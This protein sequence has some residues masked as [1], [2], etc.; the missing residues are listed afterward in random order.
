M[1]I[2]P[3][4]RRALAAVLVC[5]LSACASSAKRQAIERERDPQYQ[6]EKAV[7]CMQYGMVDEA[8]KYLQTALTLNP[9]HV[10]S[11][12]LQGLAHMRKGNVEEALRSFQG[13]TAIDPNFSEAH[14]N[15]GTTLQEKGRIEE[16]ETA[17]RKAYE[18]DQNYNAAYNLA[19]ISYE[20]KKSDDALT[21]I[22]RSIEKY[23]RSLLAFNLQGLILES[24]ERFDE[25]IS[26]Y[27]QALRL[28]PG[29]LSVQYNLGVAYYKKK[30]F[31]R[32]K[33]TLSR[34]LDELVK[35][36]QIGKEDLRAR[37]ADVLKRIE[38]R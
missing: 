37:V 21:W 25:A 19:R 7:V 16:A 5:L 29:E 38:E 34:I 26:S 12:N 32:A 3:A 2:R 8:F 22:Q 14:N 4:G 18:L 28:V 10:L 24:L 1:N 9:R 33:E 35:K 11:L 13:V 27:Q 30:D 23:P 6:Y 20:R 15:L 31:G 17:F 36:P